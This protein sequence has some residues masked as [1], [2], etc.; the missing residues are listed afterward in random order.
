MLS[1]GQATF[2]KL[3]ILYLYNGFFEL[4]DSDL[5]TNWRWVLLNP[6]LAI[7]FIAE[8][9]PSSGLSVQQKLPRLVLFC[10]TFPERTEATFFWP[11]WSSD[12]LPTYFPVLE[13]QHLS[14]TM[15]NT[16]PVTLHLAGTLAIYA[17]MSRLPVNFG[18]KVI[19]HKVQHFH[20]KP[21]RL[22]PDGEQWD[23]Y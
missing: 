14:G 19:L 20:T 11:L 4:T 3:G 10:R 1:S 13:E 12:C 23:E 18:F 22:S 15:G 17:T 8:T 2:V 5:N 6:R 21:H 16:M 7:G 9:E